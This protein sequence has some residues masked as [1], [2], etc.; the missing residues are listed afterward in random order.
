MCDLFRYI[1]GSKNAEPNKF[2]H[3]E[4][5]YVEL[6]NNS[7]IN[8]LRSSKKNDVNKSGNRIASSISMSMDEGDETN[9]LLGSYIFVYHQIFIK[10]YVCI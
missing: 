5:S 3:V 2:F 8:L 9:S 10:I 4:V 7:I 6:Y 1:E